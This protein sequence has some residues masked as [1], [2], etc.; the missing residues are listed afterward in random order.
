VRGSSCLLCLV[1][2]LLVRRLLTRVFCFGFEVVSYS[3]SKKMGCCGGP[4]VGGSGYPRIQYTDSIPRE[5][6]PLTRP[7]EGV[8][9]H[10]PRSYWASQQHASTHAVRRPCGSAE[11]T[12]TWR[13]PGW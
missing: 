12:D 1:V 6:G 7:L 13:D 3:F 11:A 9:G 5:P 4:R 2:V 10:P 8:K